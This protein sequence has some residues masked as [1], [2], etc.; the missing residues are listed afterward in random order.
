MS[1][2][3]ITNSGMDTVN[4]T[5]V[6]KTITR[7]ANGTW[8]PT[9]GISSFPATIVDSF[10]RLRVSTPGYR[11]EGQLTYQINSDI[12][13]TKTTNGTVAHSPT[14]RWATLT[15]NASG[16]NSAILQS[17]YHAPYTPGRS[18]LVFCTFLIGAAP[19]AGGYKRAGYFDGT[20]GIYLER[21]ETATNLVLKSSTSKGTETVPQA[22]WNIDTLGAGE[23]NPSGLTLDIEKMQILVI[24][25]QA[26]YV[27]RVIVGFDIGGELVPVHQFLCANEEAFPYIAQASLPIRYEVGGTAGTATATVMHAVCSSV[28]SE[29]GAD[30][31]AIPAR[32][33]AATG[34]TVS[35]ASAVAVIIRCKE[36]LGGIDQNA[37]VIPTEVDVSISDAGAWVSV[38]LNPTI[39]AGTFEDVSAGMST[40]ETSFAGNAGT[41]PTISANGT[42]IDR[43]YVPASAQ[44]RAEKSASLG[45]KIVMAYSHLLGAGDSLAVLIEGG[46]TTDSFVSVKWKEIR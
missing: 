20:N 8:T 45:G 46:A 38:L 44:T 13:D 26:L 32:T 23:L 43:F 18:Q 39:S 14:E 9:F 12:W 22:S 42:L 5:L 30:L 28:I 17:H 24:G 19:A 16:V 27:G 35:L 21:T 37:V 33:F 2:N 10:S 15:A 29:G 41:D 1:G 7:N 34:A 25:M 11:F 40:V 4:G 3:L 31:A 36:Q 6:E